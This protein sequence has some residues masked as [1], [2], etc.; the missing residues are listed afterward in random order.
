VVLMGGAL[1]LL[2]LDSHQIGGFA[3]ILQC[4]AG[5]FLGCLVA[6]FAAWR[7]NVLPRGST[8]AALA[9]MT[10][11]LC[12]R[13]DPQFTITIFFLSAALIAAVVCSPD[14]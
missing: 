7:P 5:Y 10:A 3:E 13:T 14:D 12:T 1:V 4:L 6:V 9:A 2:S 8:F 11:F